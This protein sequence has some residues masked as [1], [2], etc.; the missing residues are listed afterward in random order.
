MDLIRDRWPGRRR[1]RP[2]PAH[3]RRLCPRRHAA[4]VR[5]RRRPAADSALRPSA[6]RARPASEGARNRTTTGRAPDAGSRPRSRPAPESR[7]QARAGGRGA[8]RHP[9][10]PAAGRAVAAKGSRRGVKR[11]VPAPARPGCGVRARAWLRR[12]DKP[13]A[14]GQSA[15][16]RPRTPLRQATCP[17][18]VMSSAPN[19]ASRL[20]SGA[21]RNSWPQS[22]RHRGPG[23][24]GVRRHQHAGDTG[25][26]QDQPPG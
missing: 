5:P 24:L 25:C 18:P 20:S 11:R 17:P 1:V 3:G 2:H 19:H 16:A 12:Q 23:M 14:S 4:S 21:D 6:V 7:L 10:C 26:H 22:P 8:R 15:C 13:T 9:A